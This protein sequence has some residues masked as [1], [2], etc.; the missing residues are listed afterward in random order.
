MSEP[1][2][3]EEMERLLGPE[4]E[5]VTCER[6]FEL[7]DEYAEAE[8]AGADPATE[9]PRMRAHI[10]GCPAC[11]EDLESLVAL[12]AGEGGSSG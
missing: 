6:C 4:G 7:L 5:E 1:R 9:M 12:I 8:A 10:E 3:R 11:R 2:T